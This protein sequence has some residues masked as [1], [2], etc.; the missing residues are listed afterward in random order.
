MTLIHRDIQIGP[1]SPLFAG[2]VTYWLPVALID[3]STRTADPYHRSNQDDPRRHLV[4]FED[5][6]VDIE[7]DSRVT[8]RRSAHHCA[9]LFLLV[10]SRSDLR[11]H[12]TTA[13]NSRGSKQCSRRSR[14]PT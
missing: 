2:R 4:A 1:P 14:G 9:V 7:R 5:M 6:P 3:S 12:P 10:A 8:P 13:N 11:W